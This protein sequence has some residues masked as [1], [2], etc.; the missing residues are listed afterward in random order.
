[1]RLF[2]FW[3]ILPTTFIGS[4]DISG[5]VNQLNSV[6]PSRGSFPFTFQ[7]GCRVRTRQ[8]GFADVGALPQTPLTFFQQLKKA[9]AED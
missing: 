6:L 3:K 9:A 5:E 4:I 1:V 7:E 8:F 2:L